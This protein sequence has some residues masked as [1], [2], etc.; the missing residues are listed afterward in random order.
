MVNL[1]RTREEITHFVLKYSGRPDDWSLLEEFDYTD[2]E[3]T[4]KS[5]ENMLHH[6]ILE[7]AEQYP[8]LVEYAVETMRPKFKMVAM[9]QVDVFVCDI[10]I[11]QMRFS[12]KS[13]FYYR[14]PDD[15]STEYPFYGKYFQRLTKYAKR[16]KQKEKSV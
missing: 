3:G 5:M 8:E 9:I 6:W 13:T 16:R 11:D 4:W 2:C 14:S 10:R 7:F 15:N 12:E 1:P